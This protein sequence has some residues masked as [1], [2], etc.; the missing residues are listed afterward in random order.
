MQYKD[1]NKEIEKRKCG[2]QRQSRVSQ[3]KLKNDNK[4]IW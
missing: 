4:T 1:Q 2:T 3:K